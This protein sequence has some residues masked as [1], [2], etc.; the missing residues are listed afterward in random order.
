MSEMQDQAEAAPRLWTPEGFRPDEW[1]HA[2]NAEALSGNGRYILPLEA[3]LA[4]DD[5]ERA[6]LA[7]RVGVS[8][9]AG[10]KLDALLPHLQE[11]P[12]VALPF[13]AFNDGRSYSKAVLLRQRHGYT[14]ELRATG[15][16]LIDQIPQMLRCGFSTFEIV[17]KTALARLE[18]GR[19]VGIPL[20]YQ[21]ATTDK[22]QPPS[23]YSWRRRSA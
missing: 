9:P 12:L 4:L 2:E 14:G 17:N 16:V 11:L 19:G 13:P 5:A 23:G 18:A 22:P 1:R 7:G 6:N 10:E 21:P 20:H 8:V 3:F 15:D